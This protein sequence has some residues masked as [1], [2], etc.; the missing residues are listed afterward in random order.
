MLKIRE[1][2]TGYGKKQV[3]FGLSLESRGVNRRPHRAE[4]GGQVHRA[5]GRLWPDPG[6]E[7]QDTLQRDAYER[8]DACP[9]RSRGITS[10]PRATGSFPTSQSWRIWRSAVIP[11]L[12][13][14][15]RN[16][17]PECLSSS[18]F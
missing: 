3:V 7:G 4:R 14:R 15:Q 9:K 17:L 13:R 8:L 5:E 2:E 12:A 16:G 11:S 10:A 1:L 6:V 18:P